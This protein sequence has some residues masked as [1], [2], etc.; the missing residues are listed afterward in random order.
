MRESN[1]KINIIL[2]G[3]SIPNGYSSALTTRLTTLYGSGN[4]SY[5]NASVGG[6]TIDDGTATCM[7]GRSAIYV[8]NNVYGFA[9]YNILLFQELRNEMN[10]NGSTPAQAKAKLISYVQSIKASLPS[11]CILKAVFITAIAD[12]ECGANI[13]TANS[14]VT[15]DTSGT[16]DNTINLYGY[17]SVNGAF[18][19]FT[20]GIY[21]ADQTHPN[22]TGYSEAGIF[23]ANQLYSLYP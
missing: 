13:S 2:D 3:N 11:Y 21:N 1:T 17:S 8:K 5:Y 19:D 12:N 9:R 4:Y 10:V 14:L 6:Q 16:I 22:A 15:A 18:N 23:I 7:Q 20:S